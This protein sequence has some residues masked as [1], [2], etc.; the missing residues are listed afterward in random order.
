M[1]EH[2]VSPRACLAVTFTR[3]AA[4]EMRE[5]LRALV[6]EAGDITVSTFHGLGLMILRDCHAQLGLGADFRVLD[7]ASRLEIAQAALGVGSREAGRFLAALTG[8][9]RARAVDDGE[10]ALAQAAYEE[11]VR[12]QGAV[13]FDDLLALPVALFER[14]PEV[15][16]RYRARFTWFVVDEY[17]DIDAL[18]YRLVA[19]L[20]PPGSNLC[21]IGDPDQAIYGFRGAD[22]GFFLRFRADYPA[23]K[24]VSLTRNYRSSPAIVDAAQQVIAPSSLVPGRILES[25]APAADKIT[26]HEAASEQAEA[27]FVVRTIEHLL[28]GHSFFSV[29]SGRAGMAASP[30][31]SFADFAVLYRTDAQAAALTQALGRS[32]M[33]FQCRGHGPLLENRLARRLVEH[34]RATPEDAP[35]NGRIDAA[36]ARL[37]AESA[38]GC[39]DAMASGDLTSLRTLAI[40]AAN[41]AAG[42]AGLLDELALGLDV[43]RWDSRADR[44]SLLTLHA[45]KGLEFRVVFIVGCEDGLLPLRFGR[46]S[47]DAEVDE[48]RRLFFVGLTRARERLFLSHAK[49]RLWRGQLRAR[50]ASPFLT[51][52]GQELVERAVATRLTRAVAIEDPQLELF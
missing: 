36:L 24:V 31:A 23:A 41:G 22:V 26:L 13:D 2:G 21:I 45:A 39:A 15:L 29:D 30:D 37:A 32:G 27:E 44:I 35:L 52:I 46:E 5:R 20:A 6:P 9:K 4:Q 1:R 49:K 8:R 7:E 34:L 19:L 10:L 40:M 51:A 42:L 38:N 48:E 18:Q 50:E 3:R 25:L 17:Q 14:A 12:A 33:P 11:A 16:A 43:D 28:G 47:A